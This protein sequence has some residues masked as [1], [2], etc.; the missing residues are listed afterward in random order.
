MVTQWPKVKKNGPTCPALPMTFSCILDVVG[1]RG[2]WKNIRK[3]KNWIYYK[4]RYVLRKFELLHIVDF[5]KQCLHLQLR[6]FKISDIFCFVFLSPIRKLLYV[7]HLWRYVSTCKFYD[8]TIKISKVECHIFLVRFTFETQCFSF[9]KLFKSMWLTFHNFYSWMFQREWLP[10]KNLNIFIFLDS[11]V[12][13]NGMFL[14]FVGFY[15]F[16]KVSLM[17]KFFFLLC[18]VMSS[19][20]KLCF[21]FTG[22]LLSILKIAR[23]SLLIHKVA[24][25]WVSEN[26]QGLTQGGLSKVKT[27]VTAWREGDS[28]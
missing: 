9:S 28:T 21:C 22:L 25:K 17:I 18:E 27:L 5:L 1:G 7:I 11:N 24:I 19:S 16:K 8:F 6:I 23:L 3:V 13:C 14:V 15:D 20:V 26:S 10:L 12:N 4:G 2:N